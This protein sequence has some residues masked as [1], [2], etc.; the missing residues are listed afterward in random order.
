MTLYR[1]GYRSE[2]RHVADG[3]RTICGRVWR[4]AMDAD[5]GAATDCPNCARVLEWRA[6][7]PAPGAVA[8]SPVVAAPVAV[9][10]DAALRAEVEALRG[11]YRSAM[12]LVELMERD[13]NP[14]MGKANAALRRRNADLA[15][16]LREVERIG[17]AKGVVEALAT[18]QEKIRRLEARVKALGGAA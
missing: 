7:R 13:A 14:T 17:G 4:I 18:A 15:G 3:P 12:A 1:T 16:Q 5:A 2:T 9:D 11:Q 10:G 6:A 8:A